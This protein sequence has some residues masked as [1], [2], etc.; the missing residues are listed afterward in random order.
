MN[1]NSH[2]TS[3]RISTARRGS[4]EAQGQL[5]EAYRNYLR[6]V[7]RLGMGDLLR[8]KADPSDLVQETLLKAHQ[9]FDQF[10]GQTEAEL[11]AWLRQILVHRLVDLARRYRAAATPERS[12]ECSLEDL[13]DRSSQVLGRFLIANASSPSQA[14]QRRELSVVLADALAELSADHREVIVLRSIEERDWDEVA[15][16]MTR[17]SGAAR[18][19]WT[20]ALK[21]LRPLI[22]ARL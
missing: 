9:R 13:L 16:R 12:R 5:L 17:S 1:G 20:R 11:A 4:L 7:A 8:G 6:L 3:T 22:E 14:A 19:L 10:R 21:Q 15:R 2:D 18:V